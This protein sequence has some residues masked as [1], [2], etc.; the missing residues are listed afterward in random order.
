MNE[1]IDS[2]EELKELSPTEYFTKVKDLCQTTTE[3]DIRILLTHVQILMKKPVITGQMAMAKKLYSQAQL[4]LKEVEAIRFGY[5]TYVR[6]DDV[7]YYIKDIS[8]KLVKIIELE[9]YEREVPD[10]VVEKI[11]VLK[12]NHIFDIFLVMFTDYTGEQERSVEKAKRDKDPILFGCFIDPETKLASSRLFFIADWVDEY[13]DLTLEQM[14]EQYLNDTGK[15]I[16]NTIDTPMTVEE[17][18]EYFKKY[19]EEASNKKSYGDSDKE[20]FRY[21]SLLR[22]AS[23]NYITTIPTTTVVNDEDDV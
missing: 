1:T 5:N 20:D 11:M 3:E 18:K 2:K 15:D 21:G 19:D 4:L 17:L 7:I 12:E 13:C 6:R 10:D 9:N 23:T 22:T 16:K 14:M 8:K